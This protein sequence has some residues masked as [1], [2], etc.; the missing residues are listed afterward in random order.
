MTTTSFPFYMFCT[1]GHVAY[2]ITT[3]TPT[4][5]THRPV[6]AQN[7]EAKVVNTQRVPKDMFCKIDLCEACLF[8]KMA[9]SKF[10]TSN[11]R[12]SR[13][14]ELVHS[15]ICGPFPTQSPLKSKYF[16]SFIDD[17]TRF[18]IL[19]FL[20]SKDQ[21]FIAFTNYKSLTEKQLNLQVKCLQSNRGEEYISNKFTI[22][23]KD[24][25]ILQQISAP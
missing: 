24:H 19:T 3:S 20:K 17:Y 14:L 1:F 8:G 13:P 2:R 6:C 15:D 7:G 18:T 4:K 23:C 10:P 16:I 9:S 22:F 5:T 25:G 12:R 21:A 11:S